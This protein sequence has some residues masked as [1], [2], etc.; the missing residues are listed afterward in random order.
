MLLIKNQFHWNFIW[1]YLLVHLQS[2]GHIHCLGSRLLSQFSFQWQTFIYWDIILSIH[3]PA[4]I[5]WQH[6]WNYGYPLS[7]RRQRF[8]SLLL[9][10]DFIHLTILHSTHH[11]SFWL[12][13]LSM[14]QKVYSL[15]KFDEQ[16]PNNRDENYAIDQVY[17]V[18]KLK[19]IVTLLRN[20]T[21]SN[22][23][24]FSYS[25]SQKLSKKDLP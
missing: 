7:V 2:A 1:T 21:T 15:R 8:F 3:N 14:S 10:N 16:R 11:H 22:N 4:V 6:D 24:L 18:L 13:C 19:S 25:L 5:L 9:F 23:W 20:F 17:K 12:K